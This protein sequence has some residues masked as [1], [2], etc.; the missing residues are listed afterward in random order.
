MN[1]SSF[2]K[3]I[4]IKNLGDARG[5]LVSF[6]SNKSIPF[7]I[8]R[9]YSLLNTIHSRGY[10]AHKELKQVLVCLSGKCTVI[11][12]NGFTKE[13]VVLDS[14]NKGLLIEAMTWREMHEFSKDCV[15]LVL[16]SEHYNEDDYI[17]DYQT[18]IKLVSNAQNT[19]AV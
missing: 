3:L 4:E 11:L 16:A 15:L 6:E 5:D 19:Y 2:V 18:F 7:Q 12:D 8:K 17:R 14:F 10:H 9:V 1:T 13:S